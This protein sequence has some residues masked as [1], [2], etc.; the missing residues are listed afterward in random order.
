MFK[1]TDGLRSGNFAAELPQGRLVAAA[2]VAALAVFLLSDQAADITG[3]VVNV[4]G[5]YSL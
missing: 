1:Q 3:S 4:D 2:G 5:G